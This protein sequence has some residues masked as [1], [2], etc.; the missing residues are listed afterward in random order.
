VV[1]SKTKRKRTKTAK[2][3]SSAGKK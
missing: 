1:K 2:K 3:A